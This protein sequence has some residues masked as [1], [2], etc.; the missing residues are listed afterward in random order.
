MGEIGRESFPTPSRARIAPSR[1]AGRAARTV[2]ALGLWLIPQVVGANEVLAP[3]RRDP[4]RADTSRATRE[5]AV[6]S[7][8]LDQ[9]SADSRAKVAWVLANTSVF[10]RLP[11]RVVQCD[12]DLY[13]FLVH[14]PDIVVNIWQVLGVGNLFLEQTGPETFK[15]T[16][17]IGTTGH[18]QFL[19]RSHDTNLIYVDGTYKGSTFGQQIRARG[20]MILKSGYVRETDGRYY[21]TSRLDAFM[22]IEPGG[23]EFLTKTFQPLVGK[24]ADNNFLQTAGFLGSLSRT[25]EVNNAGMQRLAKK[26]TKVQPEVRRQFAQLSDKVAQRAV[27]TGRAGP[28]PGRSAQAQPRD[29]MIDAHRLAQRPAPTDTLSLKTPK[30]SSAPAP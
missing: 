23:M 2:L 29:A 3:G 7:I 1:S 6:Q 13:L 14:H 8:P 24:I 16:D 10:R 11:V 18:L 12:P 4:T 21:V 5:C 15:V 30:P 27:A 20:V 22:N 19:H 17:E 28:A 26:L 9:L 25:A